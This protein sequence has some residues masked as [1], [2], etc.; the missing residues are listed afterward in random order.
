MKTR[1]IVPS[2]L[3]IST[4]N[5]HSAILHGF[6]RPWDHAASLCRFAF[7]AIKL[8]TISLS[9]SSDK[10][11]SLVNNLSVYNVGSSGEV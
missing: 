5:E 3:P 8:V 10:G 4:L 7:K 2:K 1:K 6:N 9:S 11:Y